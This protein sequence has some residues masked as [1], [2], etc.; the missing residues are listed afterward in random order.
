MKVLAESRKTKKQRPISIFEVLSKTASRPWRIL[1]HSSGCQ[2]YKYGVHLSEF[3]FIESKKSLID[4]D[5]RMGLLVVGEPLNWEDTKKHA[6]Y[7][8]NA[9]LNKHKCVTVVNIVRIL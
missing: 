4:L 5:F 2:V 9:G 7:V 6:E 1:E 3:Q 8:R